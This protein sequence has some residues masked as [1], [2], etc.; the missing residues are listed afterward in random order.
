VA[1]D[2]GEEV[3]LLSR[4]ASMGGFAAADEGAGEIG[5]FRGEDPQGSAVILLNERGHRL[6]SSARFAVDP[7]HDRA[8]ASQFLPEP[9]ADLAFV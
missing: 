6:H 2:I 3:V 4:E 5:V 8:L 9:V 7:Q 1:G